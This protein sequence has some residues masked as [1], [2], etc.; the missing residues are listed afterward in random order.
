[1]FFFAGNCSSTVAIAFIE[2]PQSQTVAIGERAQFRCRHPTADYIGW[3]VNGS[4]LN[5]INLNNISTTSIPL[6]GGH[7]RYVLL[8][9][10]IP[11]YNGTIVICVARFLNEC[12]SQE[13]G[14][15]VLLIQG[16]LTKCMNLIN[17]YDYNNIISI[18]PHVTC[19]TLLI[20]FDLHSSLLC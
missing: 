1:M 16:R 5:N 15:A 19:S 11:T 17:I 10:A 4:S 18:S 2:E 12:P 8:I 20:A 7:S 14:P 13:S 3:T 6:P 9:G